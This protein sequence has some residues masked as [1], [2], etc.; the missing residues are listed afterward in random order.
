MADLKFH[1][2]VLDTAQT[3]FDQATQNAGASGANV[4]AAEAVFANAKRD[5][6]GTRGV[7]KRP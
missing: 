7:K 2:A 6:L 4:A 3:Q 5:H 1:W